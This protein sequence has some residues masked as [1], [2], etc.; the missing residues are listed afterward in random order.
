MASKIGGIKKINILRGVVIANS[1]LFILSV[2]L[3][4]F[5]LKASYLWFFF[6]CF[7]VGEYLLVKSY[8]YN[9]D[10]NFYLGWL[11]LLLGASYLANHFLSFSSH[12]YLITTPFVFAGL[13]TFC[14]Y[15]Q[16]FHLFLSFLLV[17]VI[18]FYFMY[19]QNIINIYIFFALIVLFIFIFS[20][21][22]VRMRMQRKN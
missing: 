17:F 20:F 3:S 12:F 10:S 2:F 16:Y 5:V 13:L 15:K 11:L 9:A 6:F 18:I 19:R 8:L 22:Y 4:I 21:I 7:F 14:K 1:M